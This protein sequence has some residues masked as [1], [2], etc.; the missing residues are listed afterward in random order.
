MSNLILSSIS[1]SD[2]KRLIKEC[3]REELDAMPRQTSQPTRE[4]K[5][6][7]PAELARVLNVSR[8]TISNWQKQ[9]AISGRVIGGR[10]Y[11]F[12]SEI[13]EKGGKL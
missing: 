10:R 12:L 4:E 1:I 9:G 8:Q 7:T 3:I 11:Y 5:P 13:K 2:L 6:L